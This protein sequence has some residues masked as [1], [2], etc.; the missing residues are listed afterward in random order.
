MTV[1]VLYVVGSQD[2][3]APPPVM[4]AMAEATPNAGLSVI[5][6]AAHIPNMEDPA[7][8]EAVIAPWLA[9]P[10]RSAA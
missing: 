9:A 1:P 7:A 6:G 5:E 8:F 2:A 3:G 4:Q 10:A